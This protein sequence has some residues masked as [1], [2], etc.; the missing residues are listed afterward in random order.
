M[1]AELILTFITM[2]RI[3]REVGLPFLLSISGNKS[4][5]NLVDKIDVDL[6]I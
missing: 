5:R 3:Y 6:I 1:L 4:S 2:G